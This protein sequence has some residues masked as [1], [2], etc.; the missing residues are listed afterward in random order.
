MENTNQKLLAELL[1]VGLRNGPFILVKSIKNR[2]WMFFED[3]G[4]NLKVMP[5]GLAVIGA[6]KNPWI[7]FRI[8][9]KV[10]PLC[11]FSYE[12]TASFLTDVSAQLLVDANRAISKYPIEEIIRRLRNGIPLIDR[13]SGPIIIDR[14]S[15]SQG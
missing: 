1:S 5:A 2:T 14:L 11:G 9:Q 13:G 3:D 10:F 6:F 4:K 12:G 7:A 15:N 8:F